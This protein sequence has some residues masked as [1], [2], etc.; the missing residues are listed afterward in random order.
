METTT[1]Q[2]GGFIFDARAGGPL[3]GE[4][5]LLLHGFP[6]SSLEWREQIAALAEAGYRAVAPDQRGYSA[7]ARPLAVEAYRMESLVA[8]VLGIAGA[9]G[10]DRFH[11]VGHDWGAAVAWVVAGR[12]ADRVLTLTSLS[13]PH[14]DAFARSLREGEQRELSSYMDFFR[15]AGSEAAFLAR[16]GAML[17]GFFAVL[18]DEVA[19]EY[20]RFLSA[21]DGATLTGGLNWYR[22]NQLGGQELGPIAVP[23]LFIWGTDDPALGREAADWTAHHVTG[24][25]RY[26]VLDGAGHWLAEERAGDVTRL[27]LEHLAAHSMSL[28]RPASI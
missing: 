5:V 18:G 25:Y 8:D 4:L 7:G 12:H 22:A 19:G 11:L 26:E 1:I 2:A 13:T 24:P 28:R 9:L 16:D 15:S 23:T 14:L 10:A 3:G 6:Q 21:G 27:L 17:R 20:V